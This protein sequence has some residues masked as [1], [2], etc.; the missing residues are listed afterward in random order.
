MKLNNKFIVFFQGQNPLHGHVCSLEADRPPVGLRQQVPGPVGLQAAGPHE[1][2]GRRGRQGP[3]HEH[4]LR[5]RQSQPQ[6]FH[7]VGFQLSLGVSTVETNQDRDRDFSICRDQ[8]LKL[9]EIILTVETRLFFVSVKIFKIETFES[10]LSIETL[11]RDHVETNLDPR[12]SFSPLVHSSWKSTG[13]VSFFS[14]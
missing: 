10:R 5:P 11:N 9:V 3:L 6:H 7:K 2:A 12:L 4:A 1:H 8:L 14:F 13:V